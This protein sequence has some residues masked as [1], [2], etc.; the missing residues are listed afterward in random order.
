MSHPEQIVASLKKHRP[1]SGSHNGG[2][3][4]G[5]NQYLRSLFLR[6]AELATNTEFSKWRIQDALIDDC[7]FKGDLTFENCSFEAPFRISKLHLAGNLIFRNCFFQ[8]KSI[9]LQK[10]QNV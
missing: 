6:E 5:D 3:V 8:G 7:L 9:R 1:I 10:S 2:L 4:E